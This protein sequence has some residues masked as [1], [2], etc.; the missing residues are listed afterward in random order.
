[1]VMSYREHG[2]IMIVRRDHYYSYLERVAKATKNNV[3]CE[4]C[5]KDN[6]WLRPRLETCSRTGTISKVCRYFGRGGRCRKLAFKALHTN[7]CI[8][9]EPM[10]G[11]GA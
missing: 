11:T 5:S 6:S 1:M 4:S 8:P 2:V 7:G 3:F 10:P 9:I